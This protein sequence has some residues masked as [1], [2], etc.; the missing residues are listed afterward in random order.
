ADRAH[1]EALAASEPGK[2][3]ITAAANLLEQPLP[4]QPDDLFLEFS[5]NG[6]RTRWQTVAG[7]RRSRLPLLAGAECLE[8]RGRF[9]P[10][11]EAVIQA[12][13]AEKTWV[14]PA[15]DVS[16]NNFNGKAIDVDLAS[17]ALGWQLAVIDWAMGEKLGAEV[18]ASL[19]ANV[20]QRVVDPYLQMVTGQ[21]KAN[22]W[23]LGSNN[24]NSVCHAG[25]VGATLA[26]T[27]SK[28]ERARV[29]AAAEQNVRRFLQGFTSDG[30]CSEGVG[31]WNYGFGH[32]LLLAEV[33]FQA[34][35][36]KLDLMADPLVRAPATFGTNIRITPARCPAFADCAVNALPSPRYVNFINRRLCLQKAPDSS[37]ATFAGRLDP[38]TLAFGLPNSAT[39]TPLTETA[40][41]LLLRSWFDQAGVY[42]GRLPNPADPGLRAA[43]K[44][45]HNAEEH[46]HNDLGSFVVAVGDS[47]L[48]LDPGSE[49][50]TRRT[51]SSKRYESKVLNSYGHPVPVVAGKLQSPGRKFAA[52][53]LEHSFSD[54]VDTVRMS[55]RD[56]YEVP[57]LK[58][59]ERT[60]TY[61]RRNGGSLRVED[62]VEFTS[63]QMF[64]TA[65]VTYA[66]WKQTG[67]TTLLFY[68]AENAAKV[69]LE[70]SL[71]FTLRSEVLDEQV[72]MPNKPTRI[73]IDLNEA[74]SEARIVATITAVAPETGG[75]MLRNGG[76]EDQ[77]LGWELPANSQG[78]ITEEQAASGRYSLKITDDTTTA[79]SNVSSVRVRLPAA[80]PYLLRGKVRF[81]SGDGLGLYI[82]YWSA[83]GES[84][85]P[86]DA[87][88]NIP[89]IGTLSGA[90]GSWKSFELPFTPP[91]GTARIQ[92]WIHSFNASQVTAYLDDLEVVP[93][94]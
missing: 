56:G 71:P 80:G 16:L 93:A 31:Y 3:T 53:I 35:G 73:G 26:L 19:R 13:C 62:R 9:L 10:A 17:S 89:A 30:Y 79:G 82:R 61:D 54:E 45:G 33:M 22:W 44:G 28:D 14:M 68:D 78:S 76:F 34:T 94:P 75:P 60:F 23:V 6:N 29:L 2:Q 69:E 47:P 5:R 1:W 40:G 65:L 59:L 50:Y 77:T 4:E 90:P 38:E 20:R 27:E 42:I 25:V 8:N 92:L 51:F 36:G 81:V 72:H 91:A 7:R 67:P 11:L 37:F 55:L 21:R 18:R 12:L 70:V 66:V 49:E 24:W 52:Q 88:G 58:T 32:F 43:F 48:L 87:R 86:G 63:P 39:A 15:H 84:L 83:E 74:V 46:N 57:E 85:N 41:A 64:A